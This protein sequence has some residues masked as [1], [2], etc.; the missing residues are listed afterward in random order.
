MKI[1]VLGG[2]GPEATGYFYTNLIKRL[3][4]RQLIQS[5]ADFPQIFVNSIPAPE[6]VFD[7]ISLADLEPY[8]KGIK[9]LEKHDPDFIVMVC[10]TIHLFY[11]YIQEKVNTK[12]LDL[13][14]IVEA[15]IINKGLKK[16]T[17][18]GT[19]STIRLGLYNYPFL[20]YQNNLQGEVDE[21]SQLIYQYNRG[22]DKE[23]QK[24][25]AK[26]IMKKN[27]NE[28]SEAILLACTEFA[29][30]LKDVN[31]PKINTIDVLIDEVVDI[32][33]NHLDV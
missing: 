27:I 20:T 16:I 3:Q 30:M 21:F 12:I 31:V 23:Y 28:G 4:E 22:A 25:R 15:Q 2:I 33:K 8:I 13:R 5:N 19:P 26:K 24:R 17:I 11:D 10:N 29:V 32:V 14:K 7:E 9:E 6:L 18:L 1:A